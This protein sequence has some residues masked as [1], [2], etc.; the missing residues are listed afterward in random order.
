MALT[1]KQERFVEEY[2]IDLNATQAAIRAGYSKKT[3]RQAGAENLAKPVIS[4]AIE[5]AKA[6]RSEETKIDAAYVLR[7]AVKLHERCMQEIEPFTD[8]K[9]NHIHDDNG[10]PLYVFNST[11]AAKALELVGKHVGVQAFREQVG[12]GNPDGTPLTVDPSKLDTATLT[13]ILAARVTEDDAGATV[14]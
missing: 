8:R 7:Q 13:A 11:G 14:H 5:A 1:A 12:V 6:E 10:H 9:G 3:A 4:E 2:L